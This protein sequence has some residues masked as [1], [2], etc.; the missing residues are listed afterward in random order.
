MVLGWNP[1]KSEGLNMTNTM[2]FESVLKNLRT[3]ICS[4]IDYCFDEKDIAVIKFIGCL[5]LFTICFGAWMN[6]GED[7]RRLK[8]IEARKEAAAEAAAKQLQEDVNPPPQQYKKTLATINDVKYEVFTFGSGRHTAALPL[9][10]DIN[11]D[12]KD[13]L[14]FVT[15]FGQE[16]WIRQ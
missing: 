5:V 12:G 11:K 15:E 2:V 7:E 16:M 3:R 13:D 14:V 6:S 4:W 8:Q 9:V 10:T 1:S